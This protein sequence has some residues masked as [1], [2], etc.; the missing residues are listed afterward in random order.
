MEWHLVDLVLPSA[1]RRLAALQ[2]RLEPLLIRLRVVPRRNLVLAGVAALLVLI[3]LAVAIEP[4]NRDSAPTDHFMAFRCSACNQDFQLSDR[5]FEKLWNRRA[6]KPAGGRETLAFQCVHCGKLTA[7]R[8]N[9][10]PNR[11]PPP[12]LGKPASQPAR[13]ASRDA[14]H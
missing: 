7:V 5:E 2:T 14:D 1:R 12:P 10:H 8:A 4:R 9:P 3:A 13:D 11:P 6:F